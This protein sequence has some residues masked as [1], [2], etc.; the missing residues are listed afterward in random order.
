MSMGDAVDLLD[1]WREYPPTHLILRAVYQKE[2]GKGSSSRRQA[3][4]P[5]DAPKEAAGETF[6]RMIELQMLCGS[7]IGPQKPMPEH[8]KRMAD[9]AEEVVA[10]LGKAN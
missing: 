6:Q 2:G 1:Y 5:A 3:E 4:I 10:K 7:A 9:Y 8:I